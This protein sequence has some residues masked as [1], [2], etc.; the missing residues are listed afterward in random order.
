MLVVIDGSQHVVLGGAL[1][2]TSHHRVHKIKFAAFV[3]QQPTN[4]ISDRCRHVLVILHS[5]FDGT[6]RESVVGSSGCHDHAVDARWWMESKSSVT[7]G[8]H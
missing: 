1:D 4:E 7:H 2:V 3:R 6:S 5:L 8:D